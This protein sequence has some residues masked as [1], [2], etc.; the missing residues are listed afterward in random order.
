[1][2]ETTSAMDP[3]TVATRHALQANAELGRGNTSQA[4][5][6]Y[7]Q[8]GTVVKLAADAE[9]KVARRHSLLFLSA[10][11][12][13]LGGD[14]SKAAKLSHRIDKRFLPEH[15]KQL[16]DEFLVNVKF[17]SAG[18]YKPTIRK[19]IETAVRSNDSRSALEL[20][21]SHPYVVDQRTLA[22][23]RGDLC[24][25]L[26]NYEASTYFFADSLALMRPEEKLTLHLTANTLPLNLLQQ[27]NIE[28]ALQVAKLHDRRI[29]HTITKV[30]M[31]TC[32]Y[33]MGIIRES[34]SPNSHFDSAMSHFEEATESYSRNS[35]RDK[36]HQELIDLVVFAHQIAI[37]IC[38]RKKEL[39]R[40]E[41]IYQSAFAIAPQSVVL[42]PMK[43]IL[44][45]EIAKQQTT[46]AP[47]GSY[48]I[49]S[50]VEEIQRQ[51]SR[52]TA[53]MLAT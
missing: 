6:L 15:D 53:R 50:F 44:N 8:A 37:A 10:T 20:L 32:A 52:N 29:P 43:E 42:I 28:K 17:R 21:K 26:G 33:Q 7:C 39:L 41:Q 3:E 13:Y 49:N 36:S 51:K 9:R 12:Y 18:D 47:I 40:A 25:E 45:Q 4:R 5:R 30:M 1:M 38:V 31:A 27:G 34:Q 16:L 48:Q 2:T 35:D 46:V 19:K 14:Y 24:A 11:Q 22:F 23:L